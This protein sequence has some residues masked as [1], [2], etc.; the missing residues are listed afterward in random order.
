MDETQ[1]TPPAELTITDLSNIRSI[2]DVA[3]KRGAF[4]AS[5]ISAVGAA[6][7]KLNN[8]L[9]AVAAQQ[10]PPQEPASENQ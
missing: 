3:V 4:N 5:E 9:V 7:D 6:Y 1:K 2:I 10:Q 8:F